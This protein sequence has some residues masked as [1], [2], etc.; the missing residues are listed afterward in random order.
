MEYAK[1]SING[2]AGEY[3]V[4]HKITRL[5]EWPCRLYGVDLGV[6]AETEVMD[7]TG[8]STGDIIKIQIKSFESITSTDA[9][10]VY[11][12][13]RHIEYWKRFCL[14][15]ILCCV[16]LSKEKIYWK[17]ITATEAY[18]SGGVSKKVSFCLTHDVLDTNSKAV[19]RQLVTPEKSKRIDELF[20]QLDKI[21]AGLPETTT[22]YIDLES[23]YKTEDLC[24]EIIK[25]INEIDELITHFPW[26]VSSLALRKLNNI[27]SLVRITKNDCGYHHNNLVEGS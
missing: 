22:G 13:D 11:V 2:D 8:H 4:A 15:V 9:A 25:I 1:K 27:R 26:R 24:A 19:L 5:L 10:A 12:D 21:S 7:E 14:P 3:L 23:I 16:D 20:Y 18:T 17:Q 6:D